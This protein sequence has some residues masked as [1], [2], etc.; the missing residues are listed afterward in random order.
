M[1]LSHLKAMH[2][3]WAERAE[4]TA[5][6]APGETNLKRALE[7]A[8][9]ARV[10]RDEN[11]LIHSELDAVFV[12]TPNFTHARLALEVLGAG[13]HLFLEKPIGISKAECRQVVEAAG[14]TDRV[15]MIGH[16]LRYSPYFQKIK[17]LVDGGE[18]GR[19]HLVW[20]REFRGPFQKK[21]RDW[22]QDDRQSG[23]ALVDKN[24]H[25]FDLMNW[26][27]GARPKRV[28]AFGGNAVNRVIEG[29]HQV[30]DHATVCFEYANGVRGSLQLCLFAPELQ[31][32]DLE[33]GIIGDKGILQ[34]RLSKLEILVWRTGVESAADGGRA[35]RQVRP[36]QSMGGA[37]PVIHSVAAR[38][39]AGWGGHLG[40]TE[41]HEAFVDAIRDGRQPLTSVRECCDGTLLA[42][43]AEESVRTGKVIEIE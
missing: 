25:H 2:V 4:A 26:W 9:E 32:E 18:I 36:A 22:I 10:F 1:G 3:G 19:P 38:R 29:E 41:I 30:L 6:C 11:A 34:T 28:A 5:I 27:L 17:A 33:M 14:R 23:G 43:A 16:E 40:F 15:V 7:V 12:S 42:I 39:G 13:K 21:S 20:C 24:C 35:D 37:S 8:P 31:G